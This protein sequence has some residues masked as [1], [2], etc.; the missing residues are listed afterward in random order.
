M[1]MHSKALQATEHLDFD[2]LRIAKRMG[3]PIAGR[4]LVFDDESAQY[5]YFDFWLHEYRLN[6]KSLAESVD[7]VAAELTPLETEALEADRRARTSLFLTQGALPD[8]HQVRLRDLLEPG[9][10]ELLFTD[11]GLSSSILRIGKDLALFCRPVRVQGITMSSGFF[12]GF[13]AAR[14]PGLL[15]AYRQKMKKV[16]PEELSEARFVFFFKKHREMGIAQAYAD[17]A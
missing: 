4:T 2:P 14:V 9:Q 12:F 10:P 3:L 15:E 8:E 17:V 6:G 11:L 13:D 5:A 1:A 16:P 7:P